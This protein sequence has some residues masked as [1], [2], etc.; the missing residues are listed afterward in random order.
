MPP[1]DHTFR[2]RNNDVPVIRTWEHYPNDHP[3]VLIKDLPQGVTTESIESY[4]DGIEVETCNID[5]SEE[6]MS[7][8]IELN[9]PTG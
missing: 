3:V 8:S 9:D 1:Q 6:D 4:L 2:I 5:F 7:A